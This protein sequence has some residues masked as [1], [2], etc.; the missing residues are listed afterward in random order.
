MRWLESRRYGSIEVI[1][2]LA[3]VGIREV[4]LQSGC[5]DG[6][7]WLF[8]GGKDRNSPFPCAQ[9]SGLVRNTL[10]YLI[11]EID[12]KSGVGCGLSLLLELV[13]RSRREDGAVNEGG[14]RDLK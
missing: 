13:K 5:Y 3:S 4:Q 1:V 6:S 14:C 10:V 12:L 11:T 2:G 7:V 9:A 8:G